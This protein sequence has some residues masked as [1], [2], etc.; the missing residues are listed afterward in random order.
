MVDIFNAPTYTPV[1]TDSP[2]KQPWM[3]SVCGSPVAVFIAQFKV[4]F[5]DAIRVWTPY[6]SYGG[7]GGCGETLH[8]TCLLHASP[9]VKL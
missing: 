7:N 8:A 9:G 3:H 4:Y 5:L 1:T 2:N 6:V